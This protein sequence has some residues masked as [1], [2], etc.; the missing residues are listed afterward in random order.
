MKLIKDGGE[1][2][3]QVRNV[4]EVDSKTEKYKIN[5]LC[6]DKLY[7]EIKYLEFLYALI[8]EG[9]TNAYCSMIA[10]LFDKEFDD[11]MLFSTLEDKKEIM[12]SF[13]YEYGFP[14]SK[15]EFEEFKADFLS[16]RLKLFGVA[17]ADNNGASR[18]LPGIKAINRRLSELEIDIQIEHKDE[19]YILADTERAGTQ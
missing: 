4:F 15:S 1:N 3:E 7:S 2:A 9:G 13:I 10:S 12:K 17:K 11:S 18:K 19:A 16:E 14:L 5:Y 8:S 6:E